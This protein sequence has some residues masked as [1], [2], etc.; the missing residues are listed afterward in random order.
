VKSAF[1]RLDRITKRF[2]NVVAVD[3]VSLDVGKGEFIV[4]LGPSGCGKTTTLRI[5]AGLEIPDEGRV[6]IDGID[7]TDLEPG[8]RDVAM[9]FQDYALYPHMSVFDNIA[10][11]LV[12]RRSKLRLGKKDIEGKVLKVARMLG[13]DGLLD[14]KPTQLSGGQQ[15]RVALARAL[16]REP[17]VWLMDEPLSNLDA[18]IRV[19]VRAELKKLQ[20]DL[21]ITTVYV[22]HDQIEALTLADRIAVMNKGRVLQVG[23][24]KEV[25]EDPEHVFVATFIGSPPMNILEC[26]A[27]KETLECPGFSKPLPPDTVNL[28]GKLY[29][30]IRPEHIEIVS[31]SINED[32]VR[33]KVYVVEPLGAEYIVNVM[34]GGEI[35]KVKTSKELPLNP[36]DTTYLRINWNK[37]TIF[38]PETGRFIG[39]LLDVN[40]P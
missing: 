36:G 35:V 8:D 28:Q 15:Q 18:L 13:I 24:P 38:D 22:T 26:E 4:L 23:S 30:G 7:V 31:G 37:V 17:K 34:V 25:Y 5:I 9:V 10:F 2:R 16:V 33:A 40:T 6:Y 39:K 12:V 19:Q 32:V 11:P 27:T 21:G 14:R 3:N 20:K 1:L 29:I